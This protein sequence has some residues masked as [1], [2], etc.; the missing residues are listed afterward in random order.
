M[1]PFE[2]LTRSR[3]LARLLRNLRLRQILL[4]ASQA[5]RISLTPALS[6]RR[7][8]IIRRRLAATS[9]RTGSWSQCMRKNRKW[10][11]H[12]PVCTCTRRAAAGAPSPP[13]SRAPF[14][15]RFM[16]LCMI[17][18][19]SR[20]PI[21]LP[22]QKTLPHPTLSRWEREHRPP[23]ICN[24]GR[25]H[26]F[27]VPIAR[28]FR[29]NLTPALCGIATGDR[30]KAPTHCRLTFR[31]PAAPPVVRE[32]RLRGFWPARPGCR[33]RLDAIQWWRRRDHK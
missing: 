6:P 12:E 25:L 9:D 8:G 1:F 20:P 27:M 11:L 29:G 14:A 5:A 19:S 16:A 22:A 17:R 26:R 23:M 30:R 2:R 31:I 33:S 7:G 28:I 32:G 3:P 21:N 13:H 10:A 24:D 4:A 15:C 18:V